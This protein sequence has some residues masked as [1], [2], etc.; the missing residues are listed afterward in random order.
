MR[1]LDGLISC[2]EASSKNSLPHEFKPQTTSV[3]DTLERCAS[4]LDSRGSAL[5]M[6]AKVIAGNSA[7]KS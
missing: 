1:Q 2:T 6:F 4:L 3:G 7:L 5:F